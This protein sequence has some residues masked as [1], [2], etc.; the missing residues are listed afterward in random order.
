MV[1]VHDLALNEH[2]QPYYTMKLVKGSTL[3]EIL[4]LLAQGDAATVGKY[5]LA[6][7]LNIFQKVCDAVAFAHA[8][9]VIHRD[10]KPANIMVGE[11]GEVLLMDWGLAKIIGRDGS[12]HRPND[13]VQITSVV[14]GARDDQRDAFATID[15]AV[16]GTPQ[17]MSPE[18]ARG[19]VATLD[20]RSDL[21]S[22][23]AI[24]YELLTLLPPFPGKTTREI[25]SKIISGQFDL[26]NA[27]LRST[28]TRSLQ[29]LPSGEIPE[30]LE[31]VVLKALAHDRGQRYQCV[32]EYQADIAAYQGGFA[33]SAENA[34]AWKQFTLLVKR[35]KALSIAVATSLVV[36][37]CVSAA[38][39]ARVIHERDVAVGERAHAEAERAKTVLANAENLRHLHEASMADFSAADERLGE[40]TRWSEG[41][42]QLARALELDPKNRF[43]AM[44]LY[45]TV[46][47]GAAH[48]I[49][50]PRCVLP[51]ANVVLSA[52]FSPDG[53]RIV[54]ACGDKTARI[55][56][57]ASGKEL[58]EPM[59]H[60]SSVYSAS[61]SPDG[62]RIV[63]ASAD[64]TMRLWDAATSKALGEPMHHESAITL[65]SFSPDSTRIV[66]VSRGKTARLWD[67]ATSKP[68]GELVHEDRKV[69]SVS[70]SPDGTRFVTASADRTARIWDTDTAQP[71][72]EPV[73]HDNV[74]ESASFSP[75]GTHM[76][77]ASIDK[78]ARLW[79]ASINQPLGDPMRHEKEVRNA[80][81]SPDGTRIVTASADN[82]ARVWDV[83]SGKPL[84]DPM[85]H[86]GIV[87]RANFSPDGTRIVTS[88]WDKTARVWDAATG[89][90]LGE[91][92]RHEK[93]VRTACF[94]PDGTRIITAS[95][96]K[97]AR[98]WNA[99]TGKPLGEPLRHEKE[100]YSASFSPDG[101]RVVTASW[102][103]TAR[104]WDAA[105]G[106]PLGEPMQ[107]DSSVV[108]A[109]F[110][111]DGTRIVTASWDKTAR[112]WDAATGKPL[113]EPLR[114]ESNVLSAVFSPDGT[115]IVTACYDKTAR[116]WDAATGQPVGEPM[117]HEGMVH[118]SSF[119]PAGT[120]TFTLLNQNVT[121]AFVCATF[122]PDGTRI[123]TA[124]W[125]KTARLWDAA[126]GKP[127][128]E[129]MR[130]EQ[131][132]GSASFSPDGT[133]IV[134]TSQDK[135]ARVWDEQSLLHLE[136]ETPEWVSKWAQAVSGFRFDADGAIEPMPAQERIKLLYAS[137]PGDDPWS[138]LA[139]WV[140]IDPTK[141]TIDP[142]SPHTCREIAER[143]RDF[144]SKES[145][146]SALRYDP[147]VPLARLMLA[148][149]EENPQR[150]AFLRNYDLKRLPDDPALWERAVRSL[151]DQ[152]DD[153]R[154]RQALQKLEKLAPGKAAALRKEL[155][156]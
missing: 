121:Y 61:F 46:V 122:S 134:T 76:V 118:G 149:F 141:R 78:S 70:F 68:L 49:N 94:S 109:V 37:V 28:V 151:H 93:E 81:F 95:M 11:Y 7:L 88:S 34:D 143:E 27:R 50:L 75:E 91:P 23:G 135:T 125:D 19:E 124:C 43:P 2:G 113:G 129:P 31:A 80:T 131:G 17:Y 87:S 13:A 29:H 98:L 20:E 42:T 15:G 65:A 36:L 26:P 53:T 5:P 35:H 128:G 47:L 110:S 137:H 116:V 96:D 92:M 108:S 57:A 52:H 152:K 66:A 145:L 79:D 41:I 82:T 56:D 104:L 86:E 114:H 150:A 111:P 146:E 6:A 103:K 102:D 101:T 25:L 119:V 58:G 33:T 132:V 54:T 153:E 8:R 133:R 51:H 9:G 69:F 59:R 32:G 74:V 62:A 73:R 127:L 55:W 148:N 44:R 84:G 97:T 85:R 138:R 130:H 139:R 14:A 10:L 40:D 24:L 48:K 123:L 140:A 136:S 142:D 126:T 107:H 16:M 106:K 90:P 3:K 64:K 39:T 115:R 154:A 105:T 18:Q 38:F 12:P 117:R 120:S 155:A 147:T 99:A 83:A 89:K 60:E 77:T 100:V 71:V 22:L 67:A 45:G 156:L 21:F 144:G 30:S 4:K 63:T 1:P 72:G 112:L